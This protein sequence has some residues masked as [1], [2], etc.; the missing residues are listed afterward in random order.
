MFIDGKKPAFSRTRQKTLRIKLLGERSL[1]GQQF[2][3]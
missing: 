3:L 1:G 2:P